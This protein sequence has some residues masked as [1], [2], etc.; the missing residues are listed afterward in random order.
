[1]S[2]VPKLLCPE[3]ADGL[4]VSAPTPTPAFDPVDVR[5]RIDGWTPDRQRQFVEA[6]ADTGVVREAAARVG[7][8]EQSF[9]QLRRRPGSA[10][11]VAA[12]EAAL[13]I[14]TRRLRS[15]AFDRAINGY[16]KQIYYHGELKGEERVFDPR[17]LILLLQKSGLLFDPVGRG[18][19]AEAN[20]SRTIAAIGDGAD[21]IAAS[22]TGKGK[23]MVWEQGRQLWTCFPPPANFCGTEHGDPDDSKYR[24]TLTEAE[25]AALEAREERRLSNERDQAARRRDDY[26]GFATGPSDD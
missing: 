16:T 9:A 7:M 24:R 13:T 5:A 20:W 25:C 3:S 22:G 1:M 17:L 2:N 12:C 11:F 19:K 10:S 21:A 6:L 26:F 15:V 18:A 23:D 4:A 14:A 8:S